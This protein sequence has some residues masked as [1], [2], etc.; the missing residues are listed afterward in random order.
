M[1]T[2]LVRTSGPYRETATPEFVGVWSDPETTAEVLRIG[3]DPDG[4][5]AI[6]EVCFWRKPHRYA[7]ALNEILRHY[8][9]A[10]RPI[11]YRMRATGGREWYVWTPYRHQRFQSL[12]VPRMDCAQWV[13]V[14]P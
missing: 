11:R 10:N 14:N 9:G 1:S 12:D 2:I 8:F 6:V 13:R 4:G 5:G 7:A 3:Y